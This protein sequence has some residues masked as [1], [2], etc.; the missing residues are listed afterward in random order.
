VCEG[1]DGNNENEVDATVK[2]LDE[3]AE[4]GDTPLR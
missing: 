2:Y 3:A 4:T 1:I